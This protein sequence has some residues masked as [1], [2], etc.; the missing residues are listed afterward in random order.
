M[1]EL[2]ITPRGRY[3]LTTMIELTKATNDRPI[4]LSSIA[5]KSNISLSYLEQL[6][7]GL[8]RKGLVKSYRGPGGGY[9]LACDPSKI[10]IA[11]ILIAAEDNEPAKRKAANDQKASNCK[12]TNALWAYVGT[13]LY[14]LLKNVSLADLLNGNI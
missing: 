12:K 4:P 3:A 5:D 10:F 13:Q 2:K 11:D 8:R 14:S 9:I 1:N 7:T 6:V